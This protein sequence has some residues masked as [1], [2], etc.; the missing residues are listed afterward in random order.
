MLDVIIIG[1]GMSSII[2]NYFLCIYRPNKNSLFFII[3]VCII[4][5]V[6]MCDQCDLLCDH[7]AAEH[8]HFEQSRA[9]CCVFKS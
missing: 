4:I 8:F 5:Y 1:I 2:C 6:S 3:H 9:G 7:H